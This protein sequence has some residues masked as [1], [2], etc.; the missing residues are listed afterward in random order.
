[1]AMTEGFFFQNVIITLLI[2][3]T[4]FILILAFLYMIYGRGE[5]TATAGGAESKTPAKSKGT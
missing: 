2:V 5:A 3:I 4:L 1:M